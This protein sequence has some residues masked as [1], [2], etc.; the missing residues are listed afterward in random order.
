MFVSGYHSVV[1]LLIVGS[2]LFIAAG[3][4][5]YPK[6]L[7]CCYPNLIK[8]TL[9]VIIGNFIY[10]NILNFMTQLYAKKGHTLCFVDQHASI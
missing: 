6:W 9:L 2:V 7:K 4:V 3:Y 1:L 5:A 8:N 10:I